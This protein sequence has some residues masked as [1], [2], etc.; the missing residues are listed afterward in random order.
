MKTGQSQLKAYLISG[1][2]NEEVSTIAILKTLETE[3]NQVGFKTEIEILDKCKINYCRG[4][5]K[6]EIDQKCFQIDDMERIIDKIKDT[7]LLVLASPSYW[8]DVT[9]QMKVFIDR[10]T[11]LSEYINTQSVP[12]GKIGVSVSIRAGKMEAENEHLLECFE[13]FFGHLKIK[14]IRRFSLTQVNKRIDL[15]NKSEELSKLK[16]VALIAKKEFEN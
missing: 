1:S 4:C 9:G 3:L 13:H 16:D 10:C 6:C 7:N 5:K 2:P 8:G 11:P 12:E 15:E 14:P